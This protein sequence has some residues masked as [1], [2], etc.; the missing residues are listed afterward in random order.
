MLSH[1]TDLPAREDL[2]PLLPVDP[3]AGGALGDEPQGHAVALGALRG[4]EPLTAPEQHPAQ[5]LE[6]EGRVLLTPAGLVKR[7]AG[8]TR[9]PADCIRDARQAVKATHTLP[10]LIRQRLFGV[11]C[12]HEGDDAA[13]LA[14]DPARQLLAGRDPVRWGGARIAVEALA[15]RECAGARGADAHGAGVG[16]DGLIRLQDKRSVV[17]PPDL[18]CVAWGETAAGQFRCLR[19]HHQD[20]S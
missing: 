10:K 11:A 17:R 14:E 15:L 13:R 4:A 6:P 19:R 2:A 9:A 7:G 8:F 3:G 12:G 5:P 18:H 1:D 20:V 16:A